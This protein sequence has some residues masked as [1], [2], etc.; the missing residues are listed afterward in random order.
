MINRMKENKSIE[1]QKLLIR[2]TLVVLLATIFINLLSAYIRHIEAGLDCQPWPECYAIIGEMVVAEDNSVIAQKALAPTDIAKKMH[3]TI[4]TVLVIAVL[5]LLNESRKPGVMRGASPPLPYM[6]LAI[7]LLLAVIGPASYLKTM[8]IIAVLNLA[9]GLA[10][11]AVCWWL[12]LQLVHQPKIAPDTA[13]P[14]WLHKLWLTILLLIILQILL[15]SWVSANFAADVCSGLLSCQESPQDAVS[16]SNSSWYFRELILDPD[17][18]V[19]FDS[20]TMTI[21]IAHRIG[22]IILGLFLLAA[23]FISIKYEKINGRLVLLLF[24]LQVSFGAFSVLF[25]LPLILVM[26]HNFNATILLMAILKLYFKL[27]PD[28]TEPG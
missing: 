27:K 8:P 7:I 26:A 4:A 28:H 2:Y 10:L 19:I 13:P 22:A 21:H 11:M 15:G 17:G 14:V 6:L 20:S 5:L 18:K 25:D 23:A 16:G 9:G 1:T 12:Y 3:R 24:S